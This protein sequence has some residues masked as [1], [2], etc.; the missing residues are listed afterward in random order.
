MKVH[1]HQAKDIM[2]RYGIPVPDGR[3]VT[4]VAQAR[5]AARELG[6]PVVVKAQIHAGGRGKGRFMEDPELGGVKLARTEEEAGAFAGRMLGRTLVTH[7][8]GEA[9]K[10]VN[11]VLVEKGL[12]IARELYLGMVVDR[13]KAKVVIMASTEGGMDIEK[14]AAETP[15]KILKEWVDPGHGLHAFQANKIAFGLGLKD[16]EVKA[17]SPL[18]TGLYNLFLKEDASLAEINPLAVTKD[19]KLLALDAKLNLDDNAN[20]R[21]KD[22]EAMRDLSEEEPLEI[23]AAK[24]GFNYVKIHGGSV[25]CMVNGAGLAMATMDIIKLYGETPANFLDVGGAASSQVVENAFRVLVSDPDVRSVLINIF[26]GIVRCDLVANG[27][28]EGLQKIGRIDVPVVVR[29][30]G[31]NAE[32]G[33]KILEASSLK[34]SIAPDFAEAARKAVELAKKGGA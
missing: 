10:V 4:D 26:G 11:R 16:A 25:G 17:A 34:F 28:V 31:T 20:F 3:V 8:T 33:I 23:E 14:V 29:L 15:E 12:D 13:E 21:H 22:R 30:R 7:Q 1:E 19:G 18:L 6:L 2:R 24:Y 5:A 27:I 32:E 9:G